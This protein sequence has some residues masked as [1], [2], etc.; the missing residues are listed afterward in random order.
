MD[1]VTE[2]MTAANEQTATDPQAVLDIWV[3]LAEDFEQ[4]ADSVTNVDVKPFAERLAN[5]SWSRQRTCSRKPPPRQRNRRH[6][7]SKSWPCP[8]ADR[9]RWVQRRWLWAVVL[10]RS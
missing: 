7:T 3:V 8:L 10:G 4:Y 1:Q 2:A 6:W 9:C 5:E